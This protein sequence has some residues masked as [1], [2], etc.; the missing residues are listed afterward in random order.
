[1]I[2]SVTDLDKT[3]AEIY[4]R[5]LIYLANIDNEFHYREKEFIKDQAQLLQADPTEYF[6][7][8]DMECNFLSS[9]GL[10]KNACEII[11]RDCIL[12]S[13]CDGHFSQIE[14]ITIRKIALLLSMKD[15]KFSKIKQWVFS[16]EM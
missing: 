3:E 2:A 1:M 16:L 10:S 5:I 7:N 8:P 13:L 6:N 9:C 14:E 4:L 12:L 15:S 11:I